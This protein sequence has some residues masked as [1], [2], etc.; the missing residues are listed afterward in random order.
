MLRDRSRGSVCYD[1]V[2]EARLRHSFTLVR[3]PANR[4]SHLRLLNLADNDLRTFPLSICSIATLV[5]LNLASNKLDVIPPSICKLKQ[6]VHIA[7][8]ST[9]FPP[10]GGAL[11]SRWRLSAYQR[12]YSRSSS[13]N[14]GM[15]DRFRAGIPPRYV[16]RPTQP[17][18]LSGTENEYRPKCGDA[19]RLGVKAG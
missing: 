8:L 17:P 15:G 3:C 9:R 18:T 7:Q 5:Q 16:T 1:T 4:F 2:D 6:S 10:H 12:S 11:A 13:V 14:T 19:L